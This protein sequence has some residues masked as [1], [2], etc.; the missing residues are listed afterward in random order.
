MNSSLG[1]VVALMVLAALCAFF[2]QG[3][4]EYIALYDATVG[5]IVSDSR[6]R[7][8]IAK[9]FRRWLLVVHFLSIATGALL[10]LMFGK[11]E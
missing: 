3:V 7:L 6:E 11:R 8:D 5:P 2:I 4:L 1:R 10:G 9:T